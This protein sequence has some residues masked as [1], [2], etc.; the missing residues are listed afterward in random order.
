MLM[1]AICDDEKK[2]AGELESILIDIFARLEVKHEIDVYFTAGDLNRQMLAGAHY[3]LIFL[4]I[5]FAR[6][7]INGMELGHLIR[8]AH[9]NNI[10]SIVYISWEMKYSMELFDI[11]PLNFLLKP[12]SKDKIEKTVRTYLQIAGLWSGEFIYKIGHETCKVQIKDLAYLESSDRKLILH[13][14]DGRKEEFYGSLKDVYNE[15]LE[16][17]DFLYIHASY[18]VNY[19][20]IT[21]IKYNQLIVKDNPNPLPISQNKRNEV[22]ESYYTIMKRRRADIP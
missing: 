2:T 1:L 22:R 10:V 9:Q 16:R 3:D 18:A 17:Y 12:L 6:N 20:Y 14:A 21:S 8:E 7:E 11:R 5:E 13:L 19:D 4:D 15:Q